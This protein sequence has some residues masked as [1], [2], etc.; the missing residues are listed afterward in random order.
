[1]VSNWEAEW[2]SIRGIISWMDG[3]VQRRVVEHP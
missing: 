3:V 1:M 2:I